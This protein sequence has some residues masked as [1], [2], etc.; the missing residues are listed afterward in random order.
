MDDVLKI[1][2]RGSVAVITLN[3]PDRLNALARE[4]MV[5]FG[6]L[7]REL[8]EDASVRVV[9]ITGA[10]RAFCSGSD[11]KTPRRGGRHAFADIVCFAGTRLDFIGPLLALNKPTIA[12]VNGIAVGAGFGIALACDIRLMG[13]SGAYLANFREHGIAA[14]DGV[15]YLLP[16]LVGVGNALEILY[17]SDRIESGQALRQGLANHVYPDPVLM[18]RAFALADRYAAAAPVA[19]QAIKASVVNG[20]GKP[21]AEAVREQELGYLTAITFGKEDIAEAR[22]AKAEGRPAEFTGSIPVSPD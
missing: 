6:L 14:T 8:A 7:C 4:H 12:A 5:G 20:L 22:A 15:P 21:W 2:R 11:L 16:R 10:G 9:V 19:M 3:R 1:D 18:D 13:E 17:G